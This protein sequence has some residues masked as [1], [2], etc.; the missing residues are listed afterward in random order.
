MAA[1]RFGK[2]TGPVT[3]GVPPWGV[4]RLG[5]GV[6]LV[7]RRAELD[8]LHAALTAAGTGQAG[9]VL[10]SGDAGVGKSRLLAELV[11]HAR[12]RG[13][14]VLTGRCL[15]VGEVG[16]P[17]LP[18]VEALSGLDEEHAQSLRQRPVL[19]RLLPGLAAPDGRTGAD[20]A[21]EQLRL[22]DAV[23][24]LLGEL[25]GERGLLLALEDLHWADASTRDLVR[26]LLSRLDAQRVLVL[27]TYRAEDL[28]RRHPLRPV[29]AE[30]SRLSTVDRI[31]LAPF[32][33]AE[34]GAFV[35]ALTDGALP[36]QAVRGIVER[37]EGNAFFC[38][39]LTAVYGAGGGVPTGLAELLLARVER[40]SQPARRVIRVAAGA[41]RSVAHTTLH[42]VS[43]LP[44][45]ELE[46]ALQESVQHNVLVSD[47]DGYAFRH[48]LLRETVYGDLLP[49]ERV[50]VHAGYA[51][52]AEAE[53]ASAAL[54]HHSMRSH[55]L[56]TA[57]VASVRAANQA[58]EM[59]AP[60]EALRHLE[61]ALQL[62]DVVPDPELLTGS[63]EL[64]L[65]WTA[66]V[67][68]SAAGEP[69]R[70]AA[71]A[72][73]AVAKA[74]ATAA[75]ESRAYARHQLATTLLPLNVYGSE[76]STVV[77]EAWELV[78][79]RPPSAA[80]AKVL[81]LRARVWVWTAEHGLTVDELRVCAEAALADARRVGASAVEADATIT[82]A[83][84]AEW[85]GRTGEAI[86]LC[87]RAIRRAVGIGAYQ[88]EYRA[89][90]NMSINLFFQD[91]IAES[92]AELELACR[93]A[94][95]IGLP[96]ADGGVRAR[97]GLAWVR[98]LI[99][100]WAGARAAAQVT[101]APPLAAA[102]VRASTL[103]VLAAQG[104]FEQLDATVRGLEEHSR[105]ALTRT[106]TAIAAAEAALWRNEPERAVE[107]AR[108]AMNWLAA[109]ARMEVPNALWIACIG[110][111]AMADVAERAR[112]RRDH[113]TLDRAVSAGEQFLTMPQLHS[114]WPTDGHLSFEQRAPEARAMKA[115]V[116]AETSRLH[117]HDEPAL[118][119]VAVH[120]ARRMPYWRALAQWRLATALLARGDRPQAVQVL[121]QAHDTAV[122]LGTEPLRAAITALAKRARITLS[123][124]EAPPEPP[125]TLTPRE[126]SVLELVA[127]GLT[128]RQVGAQLYISEKTASVHLSRVMAKLGASSRT[129]AVSLAY[130]RGLLS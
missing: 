96:W 92:V 29:L 88:V 120:E 18:F 130:D 126:R 103:C 98:F 13:M 30:L 79:D 25:A 46:E 127:N 99:G 6:P 11:E 87:Q 41:G 45:A 89:R 2:L 90:L 111:S 82:L 56:P 107:R 36:E 95:E 31:E 35:S 122:D 61:Q 52:V 116:A 58:S 27:A 9:A 26:F 97:C 94:G 77:D 60:S 84:F 34:A 102:R 51:R 118:W 28:H 123:E 39:E 24:G 70:A 44:E 117:G 15:D 74:D 33:E 86:Q 69:E 110:V 119:Q 68:A 49:G 43:G 71:Y 48:A 80:R 114:H 64:S 7:G 115:R 66:S 75:P 14:A 32:D 112:R 22:F 19:G 38:E 54:A 67:M 100:D 76:V 78:R 124:Q 16:L 62:W 93:R 5:S 55:D 81:A 17:Y 47:R 21:M 73:T 59:R 23:H 3:L 50:R 83:V 105:D 12:S 20:Q 85:E 10:I 57:L 42:A 40:L 72:R 63:A 125:S 65:L 4:P 53:G 101:E 113:A 106:T 1:P 108:E 8:R 37:S 91:R 121:R 129:E 128:N 104:E 109:Q